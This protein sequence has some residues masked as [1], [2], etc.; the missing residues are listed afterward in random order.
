MCVVVELPKRE[1]LE[2]RLDTFNRE[3]AFTPCS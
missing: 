3:L 2:N 1:P